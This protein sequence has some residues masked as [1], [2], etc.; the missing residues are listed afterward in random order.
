MQDK[1]EFELIA[2]ARR[3]DQEALGELFQRHYTSSLKVAR[4][5]LRN[6]EDSQDAVQAGYLLA[7]RHLEAFRETAS[8]RTW[9]TRIVVNCCFMQLRDPRF[10]FTWVHLD[11]P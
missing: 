4:R 7:F 6:S 3:G 5:I 8:F 9:I 11:D 2:C 10:R 1:L